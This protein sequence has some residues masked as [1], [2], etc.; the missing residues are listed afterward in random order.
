MKWRSVVAGAGL[1][2]LC[3][4]ALQSLADEQL[5]GFTRGAETLP[6]GRSELYQYVTARTGKAEGDYLGLDFETEAEY[7]FTDKFQASISLTQHYFNNYGVDGSRD[8]LEDANKYRLGGLATSAK[9]N[10]LSPFKDPL[11]LAFRLETGYLWNDAVAG[12]AQHEIYVTPE[13]DLQKNFR[14]DTIIW[15]MNGSVQMAWGNVEGPHEM[16]LESGTGVS[17][18]FAAN[19]FLGV[20]SNIEAAYQSFSFDQFEHVVIYAGPSLHYSA[21]RWWV[22]LTWTPQIWGNGVGEPA[23]GKTYAEETSQIFRLK[24]GFNF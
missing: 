15:V 7:G 18:R 10:L 1:T 21:E 22:T 13:I 20:E 19:W 12:Q 17:Y 8:A 11:G 16:A 5:F 14:D 2:T 6:Q 4:S 23:D 24:I 9:Y 3:L